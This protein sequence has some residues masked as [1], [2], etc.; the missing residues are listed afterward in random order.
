MTRVCAWTSRRRQRILQRQPGVTIDN[1]LRI[2]VGRSP[3]A[4]TAAG[5]LAKDHFLRNARDRRTTRRCWPSQPGMR[6]TWNSPSTKAALIYQNS[7]LRPPITAHDLKFMLRA[8]ID[9]TYSWDE[10]L[11]LGEL[12]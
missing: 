8:V 3:A 5:T 2:S 10:I 9:R 6:K 1:R 11:A 7:L 12:V 4:Q